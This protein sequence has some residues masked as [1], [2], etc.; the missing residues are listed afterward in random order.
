MNHSVNRFVQKHKTYSL[1]KE[2]GSCF[3]ERIFCINHSTYSLKKCLFFQDGIIHSTIHPKTTQWTI[4]NFAPF[5]SGSVV[6][7]FGKW[8]IVSKYTLLKIKML[9]TELLDC[10]IIS[11]TCRLFIHYYTQYLYGTNMHLLGVKKSKSSLPFEKVDCRLYLI[12]IIILSF[13]VFF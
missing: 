13:F 3:Y 12:I 10:N 5:C 6:P 8:Y 4:P 7:W 1:G 11:L 2:T 9:F